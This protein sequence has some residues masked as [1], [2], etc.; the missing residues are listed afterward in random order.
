MA[1]HVAVDI[2]HID[3]IRQRLR[4][5]INDS[6]SDIRKKIKEERAESERRHFNQRLNRWFVEL[7]SGD[8]EEAK[9]VLTKCITL[10]P[11][12]EVTPSE[13]AMMM[14]LIWKSCEILFDG[15]FNSLLA[16]IDRN[17]KNN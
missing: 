2:T 4:E 17:L 13:M 7:F 5:N 10:N 8:Y 9:R 3:E 6:L 14:P 12:K 1:L 11:H 15:D 16:E